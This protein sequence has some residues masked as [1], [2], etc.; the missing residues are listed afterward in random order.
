MDQS[1]ISRDNLNNLKYE[2]SRYFM[3]KLRKYLKDK[4]NELPIRSKDKDATD[5]LEV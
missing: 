3:I 1:Q 4:M 5:L 2:T